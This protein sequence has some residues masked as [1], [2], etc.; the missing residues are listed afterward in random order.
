MNCPCGNPKLYQEC[1][2]IAHKSIKDVTSA[3]QL[4]RSRY[5]AFTK[6]YGD[7]LMKSHHSSTRPTKEKINIV[8]WANSVNWVGLDILSKTKGSNIDIEGTV[9]FKAHFLEEGK[10]QI[11]HENSKFVKENGLWMYIDAL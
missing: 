8:K 5:T 4:M 7:Y 2:E 11:I 6:G 9:E 1:C 3:E 10:P